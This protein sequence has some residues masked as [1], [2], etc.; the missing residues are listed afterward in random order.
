MD[1]GLAPTPVIA[2]TGATGFLG[3]RTL[4]LALKGGYTVR[5]LTRR[6]QPARANVTWVPGALD[7]QAALEKL[8]AGA[9]CVLHIAGVVNASTP[10]GF[11]RGNVTGTGNMLAAAE[12]AGTAHF[13]H[14]S[15][16]A[17][18]QPEL[19]DYGRSKAGA[20]ARVLASHL[21]WTIIRPPGIYG[22]GDTEFLD[23]FKLAQKGLALLPPKGRVSLIHVDDMARLLM[24][25]IAHGPAHDIWEADD[26][27]RDVTNDHLRGWDHRDFGQ[28]VGRAVGRDGLI[29][30][31]APAALLKIAGRADRLVR[32]SAAKLTPDRARYLSWP[33]W[34]IDP[35]RLPPTDI[36]TPEIATEQGLKDTVKWYQAEG[37]LSR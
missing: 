28:A 29:A 16:L 36:W 3:G 11:T 35:A 32:G 15:S 8:C 9:D 20:E 12:K 22:P 37:W 26:A 25:A 10:E 27:N 19:S 4:E 34:T 33:D 13:V 5:A 23:M 1:A 31:N 6:E 30:F 2:L 17:A 14:V 24:A 21:P 7:D 18:R